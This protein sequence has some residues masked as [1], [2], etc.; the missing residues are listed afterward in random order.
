MTFRLA[1]R[2]IRTNLRR[3]IITILAIAVGLMVL[4]FSGTL[5][6]GQYDQMINSGVSQLAGHVVVQQKGFQ[7]ER[8]IENVLEEHPQISQKLQDKFPDATITTRSFVAGL[9][10]STA[11]SSFVT[12]TAI[13]PKPELEIS[14]FKNSIIKGEWLDDNIKGI[15]IGKN[16]AESLGID[17]NSDKLGQKLVLNTSINGEMSAQLFRVKG[18]FRTG[19]EEVDSFTGY[20]HYEA[21]EKLFGKKDV[22]HQVAV[23]FPLA[24][25]SE[26]GTLA[27]RELFAEDK[28]DILSWQEA[29]PEIVSMVEIDQFSNEIINMI[30]FFIV[31]MGILNTMLMSV[32]E[33]TQQFGVM[34]AIGMKANDI[35][36]MIL[37]EAFVLGVFGVIFGVLFGLSVS[38][39][40]VEQGIDMS[41]AMGDNYSFSGAVASSMMYGKY[42]WGLYSIYIAIALT[43]TVVSAIYPAWKIKNLKAIDAMRH[44]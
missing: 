16:M 34:L 43:F 30:L 9:L 12:L 10:T 7:E 41:G 25:Q 27:T 36:K 5:R 15:L 20:I 22:A 44:H 33:R 29:L 2:N 35:I 13:D 1:Y 28:M 40:L 31:A 32:L 24:E 38:Y 14:T 23:H 11:G 19:V 3:S 42:N 8:E 18:V 39:P 21:A 26:Q 6:T 4:M 17:I 37:A